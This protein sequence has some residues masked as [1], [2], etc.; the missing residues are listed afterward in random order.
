MKI[1]PDDF[2]GDGYGFTTNQFGHAL[3]VGHMSWVV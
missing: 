2:A 1:T 3:G